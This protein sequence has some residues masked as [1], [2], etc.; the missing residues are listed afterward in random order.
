MSYKIKIFIV[1]DEFIT[2]A[3]LKNN[4]QD[5][6]YT[7]V[8]MT[9]NADDAWEQLQRL[10][11]DLALFDIN[12][13]GEKGGI[14]LGQQVREKMN[15]PFIYITAY[16][17]KGTINTAVK[18][19]PNGYILKPFTEVD[20]YT[21]IEVALNNFNLTQKFEEENSPSNVTA[22]V[23]DKPAEKSDNNSHVRIAAD[24]SL[25]IKV[26]KVFYKL[27]L[28]EIF[29]IKSDSNYV[30]VFVENRKYLVRSTLKNFIDMLPNSMYIQCHRSYVVNTNKIQGVGDG[31][32]QLINGQAIPLSTNFKDEVLTRVV[33]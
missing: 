4:L 15:M 7:V 22:K 9:D 11:V 6:G 29:Y 13:V 17:D 19:Q 20:I 5:L 14:W 33:G 8:G 30:E 23:A 10:D 2:Q 27:R 18:T 28:N 12:L 24:R 25:F 3:V 32:V 31:Q 1:E 21:A 26:D 16:G